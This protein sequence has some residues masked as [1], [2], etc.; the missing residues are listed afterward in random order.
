V[1]AQIIQDKQVIMSTASLRLHEKRKMKGLKVLELFDQGYSYR[2]I[3]KL[4]H[5]SLR[6][7]SK[8]INLAADKNRWPS[9]ATIHDFIILEYRVN[10][11][12]SQVRDLALQKENLTNE[13]NDL[14]AQKYNLQIQVRAK[15]SE[16]EK[17]IKE[18]V[19]AIIHDKELIFSMSFL[20][21]TEVLRN[22]PKIKS[23]L[24]D[25]IMSQDLSSPVHGKSIVNN[26]KNDQFIISYYN[27]LLPLYDEYF[28]KIIEMVQVQLLILF[29]NARANL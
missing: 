7:V 11:L 14:R 1:R 5:L 10:L 22:N 9:T 25:L 19:D 26:L 15:Q 13:V 4:V 3:A 23:I 20:A 8:F 2:M 24:F 16:T 18:K 28:T 27:K 6:D 21:L 29:I 17:L 12:R